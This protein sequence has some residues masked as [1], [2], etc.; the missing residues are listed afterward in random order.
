MPKKHDAPDSGSFE[1]YPGFLGL[2]AGR[3]TRLRSRVL[4]LPVPYEGTT[5]YGVG[6][7]LGPR[8][9]IEASANLEF[10]DRR[11]GQE[12]ALELGFHTMPPVAPELAGP[13][14]MV[15][16]IAA[17]AGGLYRSGR[18]VLAL[19]GEHTITVGLVRAAARKW[20][21]LCIVQVDAHADL[22]QEYQGTPYSH[23]CAMRRAIEEL[24]AS[25]QPQLVQVG[26]RNIAREEHE[27]AKSQE[28]RIHTFW[29]DEIAADKARHWLADVEELVRGR[30][31]YLTVDLDG[32]DPSIMPATGT[33]EPGGLDWYDVTEL[34][35]RLSRSGNLAAADIVELSPQPGNHAPDFLAARL[36]YPIATK[37]LLSGETPAEK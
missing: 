37:A 20:P 28:G 12:P 8:A 2:P 23:A 10:Y 3:S 34:V 21:E 36:G 26:V 35:E 13:K 18:F 11:L 9:M 25:N 24:K 6:T 1:P 16:R 29:A 33:P 31:I 30:D 7:R 19:G 17:C 22:R 15:A 5:S 32:L 14:S 27:F 4:V